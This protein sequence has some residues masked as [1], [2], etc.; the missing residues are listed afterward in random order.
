MPQTVAK[1]D[2]L[3]LQIKGIGDLSLSATRF[4]KQHPSKAK[5]AVKVA[6]E[7]AASQYSDSGLYEDVPEA[8]RP[9]IV[10]KPHDTEMLGAS[11]A[12]KRLQ[13]SR[14]TIYDWF[15]KGILLAW[16]STKRGLTIPAEQILGKSD[17]VDGI[18]KVSA[19]IGD[20]ELTWE[21]LSAEIPFADDVV[22]PIEALKEGRLEDV[23][24]AAASYGTATT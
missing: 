18:D 24:G 8:L 6:L 2:S 7:A 12:A 23:L 16:R 14:T 4:L 17:V 15:E 10:T 21:F 3:A 20:S 11:E 9:F 22:R 1:S 5:L 13:V 19:I